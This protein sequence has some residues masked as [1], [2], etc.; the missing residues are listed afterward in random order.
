MVT[1]TALNI[2]QLA[3]EMA[4]ILSRLCSKSTFMTLN[5]ALSMALLDSKRGLFLSEWTFIGM[6]VALRMAL[7]AFENGSGH[8]PVAL[9]VGA[10]MQ[11]VVLNIARLHSEMALIMASLFELISM[12]LYLALDMA[13]L[14]LETVLTRPCILQVDF[15]LEL[16]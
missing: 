5:V 2:A 13:R 11:E 6:K 9:K 8:G 3:F 10:N 12:L 4:S 16:L 14:T 7:L 15:M 1:K